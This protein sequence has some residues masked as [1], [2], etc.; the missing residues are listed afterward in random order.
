MLRFSPYAV[1]QESQ[2]ARACPNP[3]NPPKPHFVHHFVTHFVEKWPEFDKV[4][5]KVEDKISKSLLLGR[6]LAWIFHT[7]GGHLINTVASARW[8]G[9]T[10]Q[11]QPFQRLRCGQA[12]C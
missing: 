10:V 7:S 3:P 4:I 12:N 2:M 5:D 11:F 1:K 8:N 9:A 6:A